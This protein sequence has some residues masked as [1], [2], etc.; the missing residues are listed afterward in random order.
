MS[1]SS[2]PEEKEPTP[3]TVKKK[4]RTRKARS[5]RVP[6]PSDRVLRSH[7]RSH[8]HRR[9]V[10]PDPGSSSGES[11]FSDPELTRKTLLYDPETDA[12]TEASTGPGEESDKSEDVDRTFELFTYQ[13]QSTSS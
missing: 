13:P 7:K 6:E 4:P 2:S 1:S 3:E 10:D 11:L 8:S 12:E 9:A 5:P